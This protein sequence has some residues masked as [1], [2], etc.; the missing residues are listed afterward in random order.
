[1]KRALLRPLSGALAFAVALL[2]AAAGAGAMPAREGDGEPTAAQE[3]IVATTAWTAAFVRLAGGEE[4]RVLAPYEMRHPP[5]YELRPSDIDA[6]ARARLIVFAGYETMVEKLK[7]TAGRG[8]IATVQ[9]DT[10]NDLPTIRASVEK[11]AA[12]LGTEETARENLEQLERWFADWRQEIV[13]LGLGGAPI[14]VHFHQRPLAEE[15][16]FQIAGVFGPGPLEPAGIVTLSTQPVELIIDNWHNEVGQPLEETIPGARRVSWL[17]FPGSFGT[18][19]LMDVLEHNRQ[20]LRQAL[21][22]GR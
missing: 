2:A 21:E 1:V 16:G 8:D 12:T 17:N 19:S 3:V 9:I 4:I 15:L 10:R 14:L 22:G 13:R 18:R 5:E 11:I 20:E 7:D 6:V